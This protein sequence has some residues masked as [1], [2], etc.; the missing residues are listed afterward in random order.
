MGYDASDIETVGITN[1]RETLI[2]WD[3]LTGHPL[4]PAIVWNDARTID[5]VEQLSKKD[6][7]KKEDALRHVCGLPISTY[8][9]AVKLRW[10]LDNVQVVAQAQ[11]EN[12]LCIGTVD[13][14]LIYVSRTIYNFS[15]NFP[16]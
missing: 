4:Y 8:F 9:S 6:P 1:Q 14:W 12:R 10:L 7:V 15:C 16:Y 2:T 5:T 3:S 11:D 13:T